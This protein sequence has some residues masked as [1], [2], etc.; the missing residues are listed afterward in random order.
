MPLRQ[1]VRSD[2]RLFLGPYGVNDKREAWMRETA[3]RFFP[4]CCL[5]YQ[6]ENEMIEVAYRGTVFQRRM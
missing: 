5:T 3:K 1:C 2:C 4:I 6:I